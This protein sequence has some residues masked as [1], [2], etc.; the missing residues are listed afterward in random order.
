MSISH[1]EQQA[2]YRRLKTERK[3]RLER[4][5]TARRK[6]QSYLA[7]QRHIILSHDQIVGMLRHDLDRGESE[8]NWEEIKIINIEPIEGGWRINLIE[9]RYVA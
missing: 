3:L 2:E 4:E 8:W 7:M 5:D 9:G 1:K 6:T